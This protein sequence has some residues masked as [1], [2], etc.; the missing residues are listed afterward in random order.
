MT[1]AELKWKREKKKSFEREFE[2]EP[3][4]GSRLLENPARAG[5]EISCS[6]LSTA[7]LTSLAIDCTPLVRP[8][9]LFPPL[10]VLGLYSTRPGPVLISVSI[11]PSVQVFLRSADSHRTGNDDRRRVRAEG[12][13]RC[14]GRRPLVRCPGQS[15]TA[16]VTGRNVRHNRFWSP[17]TQMD[18]IAHRQERAKK[19]LELAVDKKSSAACATLAKYPRFPSRDF[20]P[21]RPNLPDALVRQSLRERVLPTRSC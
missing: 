7:S 21:P 18:M 12:R 10:H 4:R 5:R 17:R 3:R 8:H 2:I 6:L 11:S 16:R 1:F 14:H 20:V 9:R 19:R 15:P 13:R